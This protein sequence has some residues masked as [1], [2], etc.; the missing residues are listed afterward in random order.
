MFY[1]YAALYLLG[2]PATFA[3]LTLDGPKKMPWWAIVLISVFWPIVLY[4]CL[5]VVAAYMAW[6]RWRA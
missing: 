5:I 1:F 6:E 3:L 4:V 2:I